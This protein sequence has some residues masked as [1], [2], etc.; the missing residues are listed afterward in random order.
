MAG[1]KP[2]NA[3]VQICFGLN[4]EQILNQEGISLI[5]DILHGNEVRRSNK[6]LVPEPPA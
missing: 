4:S 2:L 5:V 3:A 1:N 6:P